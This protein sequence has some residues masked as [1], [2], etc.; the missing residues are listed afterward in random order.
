MANGERVLAEAVEA[1]RL[2]LGDRLLA[3]YALGSLAHGG[4]SELVSDVDLGLIVSDPPRPDDASTI[5]A[6]ADAERRKGT[7][8]HE[9]LSVFWGTPATLRGQRE[10]GRFPALDRLDLVENGRLVVGVDDLR[11]GLPRPEVRE[12]VVTGAAFALDRLAGEDLRS[13]ELLVAQGV[14]H[15]TKLVLFPVRFLHTAATGRVGTNDEAVARYVSDR[16]APSRTL[17][18]SAL[19]WR[20]AEPVDGVAA[21]EL[22]RAEIAPLYAHYIT[23]HIARL[24]SFGEPELVEG[25]KGWR[26][27]LG[28]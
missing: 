16:T 28:G 17:V 10:G 26:D 4:F 3:A 23:D 19:A 6:V 12:L 20:T 27:R 25:F 18:A 14:R 15:L 11:P 22:V 1:Y 8:L 7:S 5:R 24:E 2:A 9:R 13:P 21:A